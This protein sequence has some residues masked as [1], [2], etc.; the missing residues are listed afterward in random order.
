M[1]EIDD[2]DKLLSLLLSG[3]T[4]WNQWRQRREDAALE[5]I[6]QRGGTPIREVVWGSDF[7]ALITVNLA[8]ANLE[9]VNLAG[10]NLGASRRILSALTREGM[11]SGQLIEL[12]TAVCLNDANLAQANLTSTNL[13]RAQLK[14]ANLSAADLSHADA[15]NAV[16][17]EAQLVHA[18]FVGSDLRGASFVKA[19]L[20]GLPAWLAQ[21]PN[22]APDS[23][24]PD[25]A[26]DSFA[27]RVKEAKLDGADF[28]GAVFNGLV[29]RKVGFRGVRSLV[30]AQFA[31]ADLAGADLTETDLR[32]SVF[33]R[34]NL[35]GA[36]FDRATVNSIALKNVLGMRSQPNGPA[37]FRGANLRNA[38]F[39]GVD[40]SW[41]DF[42]GAKLSG[43]RF[44]NAKLT[45]VNLS[46]HDMVDVDLTGA[47]ISFASM[48][49]TKLTNATIVNCRV[50]GVAV[51]N[52]DL[53]R[54]RQSDL[55]ITEEGQP[56]VT[57]D[58]LE[59]AQF[60]YL[61][62]HGHGLRNAIDSITSKAVLVLGRFS[63]ERK[64]VLD[65][66]AAALRSHGF[67]PIMF[68]FTRP[69]R[70]DFSETI[71]ILAGLSFFV[72]VD[73]T[74]P[75]SVPAELQAIV[76]LY[77]IPFLPIVAGSADIYSLFPDL[78]KYDWVLEPV[79][80]SSL[81]ELCAT[82]KPAIV[83][84]AWK[85]HKKLQKRRIAGLKK[86]S[87]SDFVRSSSDSEEPV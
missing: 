78:G 30:G 14:G 7:Q 50:H 35:E 16:C 6:S 85:K 13:H 23:Q 11:E 72:I 3:V 57:C 61:L 22:D 77:R 31:G 29:L 4:E 63:P 38:T 76:P 17:D 86:R 24:V 40:L 39:S 45:G 60:L 84:R 62:L 12:D 27:V 41:M 37:D 51:W 58:N 42:T 82:F 55:S 1:I 9:A 21:M 65:G 46:N 79:S 83:D 2:N 67:L 80:Y 20:S 71:G 44:V 81:A 54:A 73:L 5:L 28:R 52:A 56:E 33:W 66:V 26:P 64:K 8:G 34:A 32:E 75:K 59:I 10:A 87:V 70:R 36:V 68:D 47:D 69:E 74:D 15:S 48:V 25:D 43:A 18:R 19:K 53:T 49:N